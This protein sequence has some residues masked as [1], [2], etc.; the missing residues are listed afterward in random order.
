MIGNT[1]YL[2]RLKVVGG[3]LSHE[4]SRNTTVTF[5]GSCIVDVLVRLPAMIF[6]CFDHYFSHSDH[7]DQP[8]N[9]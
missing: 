9:S 7:L 2:E 4:T 1:R 8:L 5:V 6:D 3:H